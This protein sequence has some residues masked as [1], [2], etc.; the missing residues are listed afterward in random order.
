MTTTK[1]QRIRKRKGRI[2]KIMLR[3]YRESLGLTQKELGKIVGVDARTISTYELRKQATIHK[4]G[5]KT[6]KDI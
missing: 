3:E 1:A 6:C 2:K 4:S 5:S